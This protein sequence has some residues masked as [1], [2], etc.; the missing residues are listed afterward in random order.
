MCPTR[1]SSDLPF[2]AAGQFCDKGESYRSVVFYRNKT[3][4]NQIEKDI[5]DI[6]IKFKEKQ[7]VTLVWKFKIFYPAED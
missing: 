1:R 5:K 2:D 7:V 3:Q 4:K 6:E